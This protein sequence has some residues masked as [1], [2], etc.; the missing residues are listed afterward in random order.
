MITI[1]KYYNLIVLLICVAAFPVNV[2]SMPVVNYMDS[3]ICSFHSGTPL[4]SNTPIIKCDHCDYFYDV[5]FNLS[6]KVTYTITYK[7]SVVDTI[8]Q[9]HP[10]IYK[11]S[12]SS[13]SPPKV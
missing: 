1:Q 10:L 5:D 2:V 13:R 12:H 11:P 7:G 3:S 8:H 9:G 4:E 6:D